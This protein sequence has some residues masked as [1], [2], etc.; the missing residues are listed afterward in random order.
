M[1]LYSFEEVSGT[2]LDLIVDDE[3]AV[4]WITGGGMEF[5]SSTVIKSAGAAGMVIDA[6][7]AS[8]EI[9]IEVWITSANTTQSGPA[10]TVTLSR[11]PF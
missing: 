11:G 3:T 1:V 4:S 2:P 5:K 9:T 7:K 10:R 8:D 6:V